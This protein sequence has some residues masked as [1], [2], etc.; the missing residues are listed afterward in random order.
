MHSYSCAARAG[1]EAVRPKCRL[2][3]C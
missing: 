1:P 3:G 2:N